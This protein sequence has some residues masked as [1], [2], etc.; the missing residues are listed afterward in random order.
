MPATP[1][2]QSASVL[3]TDY[4]CAASPSDTP[5]LEVHGTACVAFVRRGSFGYSL[6]GRTHELVAGSVLLGAEGDEFVCTHDHHAGGDECLSCHFSPELAD[7]L[8]HRSPLFFA[9]GS[10][11]PLA[12]LMLLGQLAD[13]A[14]VG[15]S[16]LGV[17]EAALAFASRAADLVRGA[18]RSAVAVSSRDRRRAVEAAL[19]I[20]DN[21][22]RPI[23]L[24]DVAKHAGL[25][26]F[27]FLRLFS[28][29]VGTSPHQYLVRARLGRAARLLVEPELSVTRIAY[30]VGF[31]DLSNFVRT[32]QR[33]LGVSPRVFRRAAR[34][35]RKILQDRIARAT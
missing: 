32:F 28:K 12:E 25:S 33:A 19:F 6:R 29:V 23:H 14:A 10:A 13:S 4:R 21:A 15:T 16:N 26:S 24:D 2:F 34:G 31:G 35:D 27:H 18:K 3:V 17:D 20:E 8:G 9:L 5:F 30:E 22:H 1:L 7:E 11:P